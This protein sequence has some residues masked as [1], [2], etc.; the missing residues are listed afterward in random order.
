MPW[1]LSC[2]APVGRTI[3]KRGGICGVRTVPYA[4][5]PNYRHS[6]P[7]K[8]SHYTRKP[9]TKLPAVPPAPAAG[10]VRKI[11]QKNLENLEKPWISWYNMSDLPAHAREG[12]KVGGLQYSPRNLLQRGDR[13]WDGQT[14]TCEQ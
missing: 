5:A 13:K 12:M 4:L 1:S 10:S 14:K 7:R 2:A 3:G 11:G 6:G 9:F 8:G